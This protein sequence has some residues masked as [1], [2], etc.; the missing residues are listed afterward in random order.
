MASPGTQPSQH[1]LTC[2]LSRTNSRFP[3]SF[4]INRNILGNVHQMSVSPM[5]SC[6]LKIL[7]SDVMMYV[8][9][10]SVIKCFLVS[11]PRDVQNISA[12]LKILEGLQHKWQLLGFELS[13]Y[14]SPESSQNF[15]NEVGF[16]GNRACCRNSAASCVC[17]AVTTYQCVLLKTH[18]VYFSLLFTYELIHQNGWAILRVWLL[19]CFFLSWSNT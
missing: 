2:T 19:L 18:V 8:L 9:L 13:I 10:H 11:Q 5:K 3:V 1:P 6:G 14:G 15:L 12:C 4:K 7:S 16:W 17:F